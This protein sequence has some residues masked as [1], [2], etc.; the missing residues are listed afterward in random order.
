MKIVSWN[1][2]GLR[3]VH[4][5]D[6]WKSFI[7]TVQADII[8]LQEIKMEKDQMKDSDREIDGYTSFWNSSKERKGYAGTAIYIKN[9]IAK[10]IIKMYYDLPQKEFSLHGRLITVEHK[11]FILSNGYFPN[12]GRGPELVRYKLRYYNA[13][14]SFIEDFRKRQKNIIWMGD[15]NTAH[16]PID[17][18][19][20][21][22]NE[23]HTGFLPEERAW[24]DEVLAHG[25]IDTFRAFNPDKKEMYTW[26]DMKTRARERN[27]GWRIDYIFV[28][29]ELISK[30][31]HATIHG[32]IYGSDHCPVSIEVD[33]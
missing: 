6:M 10:D 4:R 15:V 21:K 24:I 12:G 29:E 1:V 22:E 11:D 31:T 13:F 20:P 2:N 8:C 3:A 16:C 17:L 27:I 25:Y 30:V 14:L 9:E 5:K 33:L 26:W 18:A 28:S 19:R 23:T 32:S 7:N